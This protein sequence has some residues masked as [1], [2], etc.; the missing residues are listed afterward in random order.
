MCK[1]VQAEARRQEQ[2]SPS[3]LPHLGFWEKVSHWAWRSTL[4]PGQWISGLL[5]LCLPSPG[6]TGMPDFLKWMLGMRL[7]SSCLLDRHSPDGAISPG[8]Y[9]GLFIAFIQ[10]FHH[11]SRIRMKMLPR[12]K[13]RRRGWV[14]GMG[15]EGSAANFLKHMHIKYCGYFLKLG[16]VLHYKFTPGFYFP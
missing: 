16:C 4:W 6:I 2:V 12:G 5:C 7:R 15:G 3:I 11:P 8:P 13:K 1:Y 14:R 9:P 10:C